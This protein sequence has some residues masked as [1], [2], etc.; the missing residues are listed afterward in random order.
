MSI[1]ATYEKY[2]ALSLKWQFDFV[3]S[4]KTGLTNLLYNANNNAEANIVPFI[5]PSIKIGVGYYP[6][7]RT[8]FNTILSLY[9]SF[10]F[11]DIDSKNKINSF[12]LSFTNS[13]YYYISPKVRLNAFFDINTGAYNYDS[14]ENYTRT[15]LRFKYGIKYSLYIF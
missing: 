14:I 13:L 1:I 3:S 11:Q 7:T 12:G 6:N 10:R 15:N 2:K 5:L 4:I 9:D 8:G